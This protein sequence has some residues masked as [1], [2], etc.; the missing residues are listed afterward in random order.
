MGGYSEVKLGGVLEV[1]LVQVGK[2]YDLD[3]TMA[4][5]SG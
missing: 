3:Q 5:N 2:G 1:C 4:P